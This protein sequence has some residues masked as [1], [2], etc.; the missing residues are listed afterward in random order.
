MSLY[1]VCFAGLSLEQEE[2][3]AQEHNDRMQ[4]SGTD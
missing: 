4:K 2:K 3:N 1:K